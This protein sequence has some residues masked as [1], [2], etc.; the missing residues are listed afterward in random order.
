[1]A[2]TNIVSLITQFI[3]PEMLGRIASAMG[4]DRALVEKAIAAGVPGILAA[5]T[6]ELAK[7]GGTAKIE[8]A[9]AQQEPGRLA[10]LSRMAGT[11]Q[12]ENVVKEGFGSL[13]SLL[14]GSTTSVLTTALNKYAGLGETGAMGLL[15]LLGPLVLGVLGQQQASQGRG[16]SG[17]AQFL[18]SQADNITRSMPPGFANAL[19]GTGILEQLPASVAT[20]PTAGLRPEH[21]AAGNWVLPALA[22]LALL[23]GSAGIC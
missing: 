21:T 18:E 22:A 9:V 7:P 14:G 10:E 16:T 17:I 19:R 2:T 8:N 6:S 12:Q 1:M 4:I 5:L 3:T 23:L 20:A 11:P 15:G 13:S